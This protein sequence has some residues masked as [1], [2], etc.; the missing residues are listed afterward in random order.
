MGM[1]HFLGHVTSPGIMCNY[2]WSPLDL[3]R[4][5]RSNSVVAIVWMF[6]RVVISLRSWSVPQCRD[7]SCLDC[8]ILYSSYGVIFSSMP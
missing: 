2:L 4:C 3:T 8:G 6:S 7:E 5:D 1:G